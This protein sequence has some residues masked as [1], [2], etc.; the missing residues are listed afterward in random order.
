M[1]VER[2]TTTLNKTLKIWKYLGLW[3]GGT[4]KTLYK[5]YSHTF[6]FVILI[7]YNIQQTISLIYTPRN[8][9]IMIKEVTFFFNVEAITITVFMILINKRTIIKVLA[10]LD[11]K[12]FQEADN[13]TNEIITKDMA[14]YKLYRNGLIGLGH[15]AYTM[16]VIVPLFA[17]VAITSY[18]ITLPTFNYFFLSEETKNKY[19]AWLFGYEIVAIYAIMLYDVTSDVFMNGILFYSITQIKILNHRLKNLKAEVHADI[20]SRETQ[21][22]LYVKKL[23]Q[24]LKHYDCI[25]K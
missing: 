4:N 15:F 17:N 16:K 20:M 3:D 1:E 23:K 8:I 21:E 14:K 11:S 6:I 19:F 10:T 13:A 25:L 22:I 9:E 2:P 24:C 18:H 5:Y 12:E 7:L